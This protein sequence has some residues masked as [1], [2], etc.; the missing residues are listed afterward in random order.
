MLVV[1]GTKWS[2][3]RKSIK[4]EVVEFKKTRRTIIPVNIDGS[5]YDAI[6]YR[7]IEGIEPEQETGDSLPAIAVAQVGHHQGAPEEAQLPDPPEVTHPSAV[8][9]RHGQASPASALHEAGLTRLFPED[10][11]TAWKT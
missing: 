9:A 4:R 2:G 11:Q 8:H 3:T 10:R 7:D 1:V 6:W 5:I